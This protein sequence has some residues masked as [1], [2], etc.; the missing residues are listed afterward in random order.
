MSYSAY[1]WHFAILATYAYMGQSIDIIAHSSATQF[2]ALY[3]IVVMITIGVSTVTYSVI[4]RPMIR[5]G[6]RIASRYLF[7]FEPIQEPQREAR[8]WIR[9]DTIILHLRSGPHTQA[10][11]SA[12]KASAITPLW[13]AA[14]AGATVHPAPH[15]FTHGW[16]PT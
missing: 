5:L 13:S 6:R 4:E 14:A 12:L 2:F 16:G 9:R 8:E 10:L 11:T 7:P 1:F 15:F 3:V